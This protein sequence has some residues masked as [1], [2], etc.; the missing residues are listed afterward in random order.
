MAST[1]WTW[2]T[3]YTANQQMERI[4]Q[5]VQ[6]LYRDVKILRNQ[7][8]MTM[9]LA[10]LE[11]AISRQTTVAD[12]VVALLERLSA[13]L[14][15]ALAAQDPAQIQALIDMVDANTQRLADKAAEVEAAQAPPPA[16]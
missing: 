14:K 8:E 2:P 3:A 5:L 12:R 13:D 1:A 10:D 9:A 4:Y 6:T 11:A 7:Q 15:A 16:A